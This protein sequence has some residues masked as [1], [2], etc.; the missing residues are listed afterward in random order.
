VYDIPAAASG[1]AGLE[2]FSVAVHDRRAGRVAAVNRAPEGLVLVVDSGDEYR[3]VPAA[4]VAAIETSTRTVRLTDEGAHALDVSPPVE[5][6]VRRIDSPALVRYIPRGL[7]RLVVEGEAPPREPG[8]GRRAVGVVLTYVGAVVLFL[9]VPVVA[10]VGSGALR[11]LWILVPATAF[12]AG[13][14]IVWRAI[15]SGEGR[16]LTA[17]EKAGDVVTFLLGISPPTRRRG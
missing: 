3:V 14:V 13:G 15:G 5:A 10:T 1:D 11:W 8:S 12:V 7:D 9:T 17:R 6:R 4:S 16:R 2:G